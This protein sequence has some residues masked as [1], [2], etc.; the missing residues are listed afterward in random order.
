M[1]ILTV[2]QGGSCRS[3]AAAFLLKYELGFPDTVAMG[4]KV[5]SP[6][7]QNMLC[8]WADRII[9]T[10]EQEIVQKIPRQFQDKIDFLDIG[11]DVWHNPMNVSLLDL[12]RP[13]MK[14]LVQK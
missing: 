11:P 4:V 7:T 10:G 2:C 13:M 3:V 14:I 9:V 12:L 6:E 8:R 5:N 1:K